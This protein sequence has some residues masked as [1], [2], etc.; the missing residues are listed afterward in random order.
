VPSALTEDMEQQQAAKQVG[1]TVALRP[2]HGRRQVGWRH[3]IMDGTGRRRGVG[4]RWLW[5]LVAA[6]MAG[7][8]C[9]RCRS[10]PPQWQQL[11]CRPGHLLAPFGV[12]TETECATCQACARASRGALGS[13]CQGPRLCAVLRGRVPPALGA[14]MHVGL[15]TMPSGDWWGCRPRRRP[16]CGPGRRSASRRSRS[17]GQRRLTM[18]RRQRRRG[19]PGP[20]PRPPRR[21]PGWFD[22]ATL[23]W[24]THAWLPS[25]L[26]GDQVS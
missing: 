5:K 4:S 26:D 1:E 3:S 2:L 20:V 19:L 9:V 25:N 24:G 23:E 16:R 7:L 6:H 22:C 14:C 11:P 13:V 18:P 15:A 10:L 8:G 17:A 21:P 12:R